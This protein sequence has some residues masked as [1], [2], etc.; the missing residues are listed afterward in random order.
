MTNPTFNDLSKLVFEEF[1]ALCPQG[2]HAP[3]PEPLS[4]AV[5]G[6]LD[7]FNR[8]ARPEP[9]HQQ[10]AIAAAIRALA[11]QVVPEQP[12]IPEGDLT[13]QTYRWD[14]RSGIRAHILAIAT[15]AAQW[16]WVQRG[17]ATEVELQQRA[18]QELEACY[19]EVTFWGSKGMADR[20]QATRRPKP[21]S[22][23]EQALEA[24]DRMDQLLTAENLAI[25]REALEAL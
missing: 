2:E 21:P 19:T 11:D 13:E 3:A 14:E 5:Q 20:L 23:K 17:A 9:H 8:E 16:G 1:I 18:D 22:L 6:V 15:Q 25:I 12:A 10:E 7:A 4:L 24:L